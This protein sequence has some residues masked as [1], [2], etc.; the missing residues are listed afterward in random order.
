MARELTALADGNLPPKC[1]EALIRRVSA[2]PDLARALKRQL[3]AIE[4]VRRLDNP[5]PPE[6]HER[7]RA[8]IEREQA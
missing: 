2:S 7:I 1:R 3:V 8:I 5:A 4:A 6:L